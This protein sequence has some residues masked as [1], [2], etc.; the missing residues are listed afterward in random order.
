M[1]VKYPHVTEKGVDKMDF[2]NKMQFIVDLD[3]TKDE[4]AAAVEERFDVTVEGVTTQVTPD[5]EKKAE[6]QLSEDDDAQ[7]IASRIGV[8]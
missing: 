1:T 3:A 2:Q 8:F 6:V 5:A 7:E 4:I